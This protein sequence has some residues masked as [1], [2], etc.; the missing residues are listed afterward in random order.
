[1]PC[2][3]KQE[4]LRK[5]CKQGNLEAAQSLLGV[6]TSY[7]QSILEAVLGKWLLT[8]CGISE[9]WHEPADI[10]HVYTDD[11]GN[12]PLHYIAS[13]HKRHVSCLLCNL[14]HAMHAVHTL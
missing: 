5:A 1:M 8:R 9:E 6:Q 11:F 10:H 12:T 3:R 13:G 7:V 2:S 4:R 14:V